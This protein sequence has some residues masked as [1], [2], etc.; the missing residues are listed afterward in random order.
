MTKI[1]WKVFCFYEEDSSL[2]CAKKSL[3]RCRS[4]ALANLCSKV[5]GSF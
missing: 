5:C 2:I 1:M 3:S 4:T